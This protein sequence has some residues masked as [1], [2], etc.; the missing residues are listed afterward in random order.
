MPAIPHPTRRVAFGVFVA[1]QLGL[2]AACGGGS[3]DDTGSSTSTGS[4]STS[5]SAGGSAS[6]GNP[7]ATQT[8]AAQATATQN[9][10]CTAI[11]PFYWEIGD[12]TG[13]AASGSTGDGSIGAQ[14][15][16]LIASASKWVFGSYLVQLR[17]GRMTDADVQALEMGSGYHSLNY[18]NCIRLNSAEQNSETV[19]QCFHS[20]G[21]DGFASGD[22][23]HFYYNGGHFQWYADTALQLGGDDNAQLTAA[24]AAQVGGD[25]AFSYNSPQ[26]AAGLQTTAADYGHFLRKILLGQLKMH[27]LLGA[28][29]VCTN[30]RQCS[31]AIYTPVPWNESWH[32]SL[33]H[34]VEDDPNV[35]DGSFSSPGAFGFYPWIDSSRRWYGILARQVQGDTGAYYASVQCG[36]AIRKAWIT[37][38]A[39]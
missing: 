20:G 30:P 28:D 15:S 14:T 25:W 36:R 24:V 6:S 19:D 38:Q 29:P 16:M 39:Q 21:N 31:S 4:G 17:N 11:A 7:D 1:L 2:L 8:A 9:P 23:G 32:Y 34:W 37:G 18:D 5:T 22:V 35:G 27:D 26:L 13:P 12:A 10:M 3:S 33:G